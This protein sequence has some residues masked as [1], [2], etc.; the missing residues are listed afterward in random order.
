MCVSEQDHLD[1]G[2]RLLTALDQVEQLEARCEY[3][4]RF[5]WGVSH[6]TLSPVSVAMFD[7]ALE[8]GRR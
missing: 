1:L 5:V 3:L 2:T 4:S 8:E 7:T 6:P